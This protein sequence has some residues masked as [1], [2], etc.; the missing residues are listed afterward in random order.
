MANQ[1]RHRASVATSL[2]D[3]HMSDV[4]DEWADGGEAAVWLARR[5]ATQRVFAKALE[6]VQALIALAA[7]QAAPRG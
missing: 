5:Q 6:D 3:P 4:D 2:D 7:A 1:S